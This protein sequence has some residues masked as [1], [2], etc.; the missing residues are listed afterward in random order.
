MTDFDRSTLPEGATLLS[1]LPRPEPEPEPS[2]E[3]LTVGR[4]RHLLEGVSDELV[5][6]AD[7]CDCIEPAHWVYVNDDEGLFEV[8]RAG[9]NWSKKAR[10]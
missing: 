6:M 9:H 1:D 7:G 4:L 2:S 10:R 3:P 8:L 5:I